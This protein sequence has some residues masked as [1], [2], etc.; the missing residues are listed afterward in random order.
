MSKD[1][2]AAFFGQ[3]RV[4]DMS[5]I[6]D[7]LARVTNFGVRMI[8]GD[9]LDMITARRKVYGKGISRITQ[10]AAFLAGNEGLLDEKVDVIFSDPLPVD[11]LSE[12]NALATEVEISSLSQQ[13]IAHDLRR[14]FGTEIM[15]LEEEEAAGLK[16][17]PVESSNPFE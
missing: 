3:T 9:M 1:I 15:N 10:I 12:V 11:R 17:E 6:R 13:T 4:V 8:H 16:K 14:D 7:N 5:Q 2:Q